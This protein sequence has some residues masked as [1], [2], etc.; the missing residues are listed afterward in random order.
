MIYCPLL[1]C[2]SLESELVE[3]P[4]GWSRGERKRGEEGGSEVLSDDLEGSCHLLRGPGF[5]VEDQELGLVE[6]ASWTPK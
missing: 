1:F 5:R 2:P 6:D 3:L 4:A